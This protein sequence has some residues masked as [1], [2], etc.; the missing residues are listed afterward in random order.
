LTFHLNATD[1]LSGVEGILYSLDGSDPSLLCT[2]PITLSTEGTTTIKWTAYDSVAN[3]ESVRSAT[4]HV[5]GTAPVT[6][7]NATSSYLGTATITLTSS[8]ALSGV[9][10]TQYRLDGGEWT[11]GTSVT[12]T[13]VGSHT[14][15]YRSTDVVGNVE[16]T[17]SVAF[18]V[19]RRYDNTDARL[20]HQGTWTQTTNAS[21]Y[22]GTDRWAD[23]TGATLTIAFDGTG[24][25]LASTKAPFYGRALVSVDGSA[26]VT[27]DYYAS[28]VLPASGVLGLRSGRRPAHRRSVVDRKQERQLDGHGDPPGRRRCRGD[29]DRCR[30]QRT[31]DELDPGRHLEEDV[32]HVHADRR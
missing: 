18:D 13:A 24:I 32:G 14:L 27:V 15:Q 8:D 10:H 9:D 30:R 7:S 2:G 5:D 23:S 19:S 29:T 6:S 4:V 20:H 31:G 21:L 22:G 26:P 1:P 17:G 11:T 3:T 25:G 16:E 12:S 28:C